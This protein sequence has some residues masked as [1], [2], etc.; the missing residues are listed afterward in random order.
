M[1]EGCRIHFFFSAC[2]LTPFAHN[3][4]V[5]QG[6]SSDLTIISLVQQRTVT[7]MCLS[8]AIPAI[9]YDFANNKKK[10]HSIYNSCANVAI[11]ISWFNRSCATFFSSQFFFFV[12]LF[13]CYRWEND[14]RKKNFHEKMSKRSRFV[15][16]LLAVVKSYA[17]IVR[18]IVARCCHSC[19]KTSKIARLLLYKN[20]VCAKKFHISSNFKIYV[21]ALS[22]FVRQIVII[23]SS[24]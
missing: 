9:K 4:I 14:A 16:S 22:G 19:G 10:S 6:P 17:L 24:N 5:V 7:F 23:I 18:I 3:F 13:H 2:A 21:S 12:Q 20:L 11:I 8:F 1:W 15:V